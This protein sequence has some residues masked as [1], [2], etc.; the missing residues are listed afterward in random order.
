MSDTVEHAAPAKNPHFDATLRKE[1]KTL[2]VNFN[3]LKSGGFIKQRQKD[4]FTVR[5]RCPGGRVPLAKLKKIVEVAEKYG[6]PYVH[7]SFRQSVEIPYVDIGDFDALVTELMEAGQEVAS[8]GA[9][10]RVPT[11][12]AGCE[13][14]PNGLTDTQRF[15]LEVDQR[16]FGT[17]TPHKFKMS[18]S[19]CPID[20]R[21]HPRERLGLPG[22]GRADL[23]GG[24]VH[25]LHAVHQGVSGRRAYRGGRRASYL[26]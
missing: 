15:A 19:G 13:C 12:C 22:A 9:R 26:P 24:D 20:L 14:N 16:F 2:G 7:V 6:G 10:V 21:A 23:G 5:L 1:E 11:A 18:F 4:K 25:R 8:C 3:E 17:P